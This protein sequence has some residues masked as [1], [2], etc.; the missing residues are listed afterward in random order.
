MTMI[1]RARKTHGVER[2]MLG[3]HAGATS[4]SANL[5]TAGEEP[6]KKRPK[7]RRQ[8]KPCHRYLAI[9]FFY[10]W[11]RFHRILLSEISGLELPR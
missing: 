10:L 8:N 4:R 3:D 6:R 2:D 7:T 11:A 5:L 1:T 9:E